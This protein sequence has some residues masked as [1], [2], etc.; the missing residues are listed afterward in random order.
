M[1]LG[2]P[3]SARANFARSDPAPNTRLANA[4][5][6]VLVGFSERI[7]VAGSGLELFDGEGRSV[8]KGAVAT[9]DP[10]ELTLP[11]PPLGPGTYAVAWHTVS[12][13]DSAAAKGYFA[14]AVGPVP[15]NG[16]TTSASSLTR[17]GITAQLG[18]APFESGENMYS[19]TV[20]RSGTPLPNVT[21]V[22]LRFAP[23]ARDIGETEA[24]L[25]A[26]GGAFGGTGM[27]LPFGGPY[28]V[29]VRVARSD[30]S[31]E[32]EFSF[33][34]TLPLAAS[35]AP[36]T[37]APSGATPSASLVAAASPAP[38]GGD[39]GGALLALALAAGV[40]LLIGVLG[41]ARRRA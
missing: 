31:D 22:R 4:P 9:G 11:L 24:V 15:P 40:L 41:F 26:Q 3:A 21:G 16:G 2:G 14:F 29:D 6:R 25:R 35:P 38:A 10:A 18:I 1:G 39:N 8:T 28:R 12:A 36:A 32:L 20:Q 34:Q 23:Q 5:G 13:Q 19:V 27:E 7:Q 37:P 17:A 33:L 30:S